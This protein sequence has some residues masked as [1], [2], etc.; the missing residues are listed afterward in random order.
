MNDGSPWNL[1]YLTNEEKIIVDE[2]QKIGLE[3]NIFA[4]DAWI[5]GRISGVY[6]LPAFGGKL[7]TG[8]P[9][10]YNLVTKEEVFQNTEFCIFCLT[11]LQITIWV[12]SW[13]AVTRLEEQINE[14]NM[15]KADDY[16]TLKNLSIQYI[17]TA[18]NGNN[19]ILP[20]PYYAGKKNQP[21]TLWTLFKTL[22]NRFTP[23]KYT[24]NMILWKIY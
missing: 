20:S 22:P 18:R 16:E 2:I 14:L 19:S 17:I 3:G 13:L 7:A 12:P 10:Y 1:S 11:T 6:F 24:K 5:A 8:E 23:V 4:F 9:L 15:S 21:S